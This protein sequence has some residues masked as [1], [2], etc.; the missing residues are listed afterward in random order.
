M[1]DRAAIAREAA[2]LLRR[3]AGQ[4]PD[5]PV[6]IGFDGFVDSII[7]VVDKRY[8]EEHFDR[9]ETIEHF[10]RKINAAAGESCNYELVVT[11]EKLGGNGPIMANALAFL[12]LPVTYVGCVG[13]PTLHPVFEEL[14]SRARCIGIANPGHTD[15][16]EFH[17]G[18]LLFGK[19]RVLGEV[20]WQRI[21]EVIGA[22]PFARIVA[23]ARL[24]G[25]V[26]W[27]L[28]PHMDTI[29]QQLLDGVL[30]A[31]EKAGVPRPFLFIDLADPQKRTS[32]ALKQVLHT[33]SALQAH[34]DVILG[35]NYKE[36]LQVAAALGL[37]AGPARDA[38]IEQ[39]AGAIRARLDLSTV[40]IHPRGA[41]AACTLESEEIRSA[42]FAGPFTARPRLSTGAGDVF[43]A[44]FC[45]GRL[46]GLPPE[47]CLAVGTASSGYYVRNAASAS[48]EQL[49]DFLDTLPE[50]EQA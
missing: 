45:L 50:P 18:K 16:L 46:A 19:Y 40:V 10:S 2:A 22:E 1:M 20:C 17:D 26:N 31:N 6:L 34:A 33:C 27:T 38:A 25:M 37:T 48:R 24:L 29:L 36:A 35:L 30:P 32:E 11:R 28:L 5:H 23:G 7:A 39:M 42:R 47:H 3:F 4:R 21:C 43:N 41:A 12:G 14:A 44:G 8:D 13:S 9:V 49:S 15:A